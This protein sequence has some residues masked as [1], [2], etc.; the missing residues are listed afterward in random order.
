MTD[1]EIRK[2]ASK[3]AGKEYISD[4][5]ERERI[6]FGFFHGAKWALENQWH[7]V[8]KELPKDDKNVLIHGSGGYVG[9]AYYNGYQKSWYEAWDVREI[10]GVDYWMPIPKLKESED[11]NENN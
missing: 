8:N 9:V 1:E 6:S 11:K 3:F 2:E 4:S 10:I 7:D 5:Y